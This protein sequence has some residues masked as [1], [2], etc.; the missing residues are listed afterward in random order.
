M[1][2]DCEFCG[3]PSTCAV[4]GHRACFWCAERWSQVAA[5]RLPN[6]ATAD[7]ARALTD[8]LVKQAQQKRGAA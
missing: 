8:E 3:R 7:A 2:P 5:E 1:S 6:G 4:W